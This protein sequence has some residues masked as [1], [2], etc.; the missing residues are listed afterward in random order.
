MDSI[1]K[2]DENRTVTSPPRVQSPPP[3]GWVAL[4]E[5]LA[6]EVN[7]LPTIEDA[8]S[9]FESLTD[10]QQKEVIWKVKIEEGRENYGALIWKLGKYQRQKVED[11]SVKVE[12]SATHKTEIRSNTH[13]LRRR[14]GKYVAA[15]TANPI[16]EPK[17]RNTGDN[18]PRPVMMGHGFNKF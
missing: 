15:N 8:A 16:P 4:G 18:A 1:N 10:Q 3:S 7:K 9:I 17:S 12:K 14:G 11:K 5:N 13:A 6:Q 2:A